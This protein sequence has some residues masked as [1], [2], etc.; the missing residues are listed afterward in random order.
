MLIRK[1]KQLS[2]IN[3]PNN[4]KNYVRCGSC[5][6]TDFS[7][8]KTTC[9][10]KVI[11]DCVRSQMKPYSELFPFSKYPSTGRTTGLENVLLKPMDPRLM[12]TP[13]YYITT[14]ILHSRN[15]VLNRG[16]PLD[17]IECRERRELGLGLPKGPPG[18]PAFPFLIPIEGFGIRRIYVTWEDSFIP[19]MNFLAHK[20][21]A[22]AASHATK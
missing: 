4:Q 20:E 13:T 1:A 9:S 2:E 5:P 16:L 18:G 11:S 15:P 10:L 19:A 12:H 7:V 21:K 22:I 8:V 17:A 14:D 3:P 6:F